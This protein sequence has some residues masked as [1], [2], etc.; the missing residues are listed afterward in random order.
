MQLC[1]IGFTAQLAEVLQAAKSYISIVKRYHEGCIVQPDLRQICD[2]R[3]L[4]QYHLLALPSA[5]HLGQSFAYCFPVYEISR[6]AGLILGVS[7]IFPL[8][9]ETAPFSSLIKLLQI[10]LQRRS[11]FKSSWCTPDVVRVLIWALMLGGIAAKG[12]PERPWF[13]AVLRKVAVHSGLCRWQDLKQVLELM[14]W[15]DTACDRAGKQL[16]DEMNG[17]VRSCPELGSGPA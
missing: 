15:L 10:E 1:H 3:N 2:Q 12:Y 5:E 8:P 16:W 4:V 13:V 17:T 6:L 9:V 7:V 11:I 14:V